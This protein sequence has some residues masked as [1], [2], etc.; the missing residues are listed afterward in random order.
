MGVALVIELGRG[1][2]V[3][4]LVLLLAPQCRQRIGELFGRDRSHAAAAPGGSSRV[5]STLMMRVFR[6][7]PR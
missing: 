4:V 6:E 7:G 3:A 1:A 5:A 2:L